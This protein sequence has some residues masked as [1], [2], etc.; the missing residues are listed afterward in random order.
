MPAT[1]TQNRQFVLGV[2]L[3]ALAAVAWSWLLIQLH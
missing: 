2:A 1:K 3:L